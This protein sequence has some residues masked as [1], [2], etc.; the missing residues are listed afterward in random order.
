MLYFNDEPR[1][2]HQAENMGVVTH[3][4]K[5]GLDLVTLRNGLDRYEKN[6]TR[7]PLSQP[8]RTR[9]RSFG[10]SRSFGYVHEK[11]PE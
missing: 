3:F 11:E 10:E 5:N 8:Y 4:V 1:D 6:K 7:G 9:M 2:L